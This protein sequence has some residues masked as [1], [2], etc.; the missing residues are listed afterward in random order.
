MA[1]VNGPLFSMTARGMLSDV[2]IFQK[3]RGKTTV[4]GNRLNYDGDLYF[5]QKDYTSDSIPQQKIRGVFKC[6]VVAWHALTPEQK[7]AY[8][9]E[10][11]DRPLTGYN[12]FVREFVA[13]NYQTI[14]FTK[15]LLYS[16][17]FGE[18][19]FLVTHCYIKQALQGMLMQDEVF[20]R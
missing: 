19:L 18:N 1:Q 13:N 11:G 10:A 12:L 6:S 3:Y 16:V 14:Q 17:C 5:T 9:D 4:R 15:W 7:Q 2:L 20:L 8:N